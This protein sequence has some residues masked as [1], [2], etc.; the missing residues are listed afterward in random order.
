MCFRI[1]KKASIA[2]LEHDVIK[3]DSN[4]FIDSQ[5]KFTK[6]IDDYETSKFDD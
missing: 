1:N 4:E 5:T 3:F 6:Y 2:S